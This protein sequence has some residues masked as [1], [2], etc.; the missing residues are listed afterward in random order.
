MELGLPGVRLPNM[1]QERRGNR[2]GWGASSSRLVHLVVAPDKFRGTATA[3][4]VAN[5]I[6]TTAT[7]FG[8]TCT[9]IPLADGGEG[10]LDAFGSDSSSAA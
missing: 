7:A 9:T 8:W 6:R 2:F 4:E 10:T 3:A 5:R 1:V